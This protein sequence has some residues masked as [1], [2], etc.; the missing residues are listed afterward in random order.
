MI[1]SVREY[2]SGLSELEEVNQKGML[3]LME[4]STTPKIN[5]SIMNR[6]VP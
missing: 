1:M 4:R 5:T 2:S 6:Q 3:M